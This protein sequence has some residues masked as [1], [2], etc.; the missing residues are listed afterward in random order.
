MLIAD[1]ASLAQS[2]I[3]SSKVR[4][5][6]S[7]LK[8]R[9][10]RLVFRHSMASTARLLL[11]W[12]FV[13]LFSIIPRAEAVVEC[14]PP[15]KAKRRGLLPPPQNLQCCLFWN[16]SAAGSAEE[17]DAGSSSTAALVTC[18]ATQVKTMVSASVRI[19]IPS[20]CGISA[21]RI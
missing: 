12:I 21:T 13:F 16:Y 2:T 4:S 11:G 9:T 5:S 19:S 17:P 1:G 15:P 10:Q 3:S 20:E 18:G 7:S 8:S 14:A 6:G